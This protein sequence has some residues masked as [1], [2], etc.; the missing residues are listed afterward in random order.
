VGRAPHVRIYKAVPV[1]TV[2]NETVKG[3]PATARVEYT[4][5]G[6]MVLV[7]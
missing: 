3:E 4:P 2:F 1:Y 5:S 6:T 7:K